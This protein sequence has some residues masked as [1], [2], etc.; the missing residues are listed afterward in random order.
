VRWTNWKSSIT[1]ANDDDIYLEYCD[2]T[3]LGNLEAPDEYYIEYK[4]MT[5]NG[6][7]VQPKLRIELALSTLLTDDELATLFSNAKINPYEG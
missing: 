5:V 1:T 2:A 4:K 6:V 7:D 3:L